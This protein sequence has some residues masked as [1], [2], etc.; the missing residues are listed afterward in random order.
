[1]DQWI[2]IAIS[3]FALLHSIWRGVRRPTILAFV[4]GDTLI[5]ENVGEGKA[6]NVRVSTTEEVKALEHQLAANMAISSG[7]P[8]AGDSL[9]L[10]H[11]RQERR[12]QHI[13][14]L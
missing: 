10:Q 7:A 4:R 12:V 11:G 6:L 14:H 2:P 9:V 3:G 5:I 8:V 1:M 13:C